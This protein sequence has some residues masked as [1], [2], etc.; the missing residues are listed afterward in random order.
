MQKRI[1]SCIFLLLSPALLYAAQGGLSPGTR[2]ITGRMLG[3]KVLTD[4]EHLMQCCSKIKILSINA[5][6]PAL[7][8]SLS[9]GDTVSI[10]VRMPKRDKKLYSKRKPQKGC[11][12]LR[13]GEEF[14]A[15]LQ[16]HFLI[17][18]RIEYSLGNYQT[19]KN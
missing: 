17:G 11:S 10:C 13:E 9:E 19:I 18:N 8:G 6:G 15:T 5:S 7:I 14:S 12:S 3:S 4:K 2:S 1:V 16:E